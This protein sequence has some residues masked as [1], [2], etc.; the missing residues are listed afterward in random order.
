MVRPPDFLTNDT[1]TEAPMATEQDTGNDLATSAITYH[2]LCA[3][4]AMHALIAARGSMASAP[5]DVVDR[6]RTFADNMLAA[7][8]AAAL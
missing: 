4:I 2:D 6:A 3:M 7:R 5:A 1:F 8:R